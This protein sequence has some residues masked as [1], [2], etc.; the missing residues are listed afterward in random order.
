[1]H[2][3]EVA[4]NDDC[5]FD[6]T[7]C[8][9]DPCGNGTL[10]AGEDCDGDELNS[11]ACADFD[12]YIGGTLA[13]NDDCTFDMALCEED[14][15]GNGTIDTGEDC[16][17]TNLNSMGCA[18]VDG[19]AEGTLACN[20]D[21]TFNTDE[22]LVDECPEDM[23]DTAYEN[24]DLASAVG[25][26]VAGTSELWLCNAG[27]VGEEDWFFVDLAA[28]DVLVAR[29]EFNSDWLDID[30]YLYDSAGNELESSET[31]NDVEEILYIAGDAAETVYL[32]AIPF[33][34]FDGYA[35]YTATVWINPACTIDD[36]C[37]LSHYCMDYDCVPG[38]NGDERCAEGE[39]CEDEVCITGCRLDEECTTDGEICLDNLCQPG[40]RLD[41]ECTTEG[42]VCL[43]ATNQCGPGCRLDEDCADGEVCFDNACLVPDCLENADCAMG[44]ACVDYACVMTACTEDADCAGYDLV[45]LVD[46]GYCV[47]CNTAADCID[48]ED[49]LCTANAC[50]LNCVEDAYEPNGTMDAAAALT[51]PV[52]DTGLTLCGGGDH[53]WFTVDV[54]GPATLDAEILFTDDLGDVDLYLYAPDSADFDEDYL[55]RGYSSSDNEEV[56]WD[57]PS[58]ASGTY[59]L[60]VEIFSEDEYGQA[61]DLNLT[62]TA[63]GCLVNE[64]CVA[65]ES[66]DTDTNTCVGTSCTENADCADYD[67]VCNTTAGYC[68]ECVVDGDCADFYTCV[69]A[70]CVFTC[71]DDQFE[72]NDNMEQALDIIAASYE[73]F[74]CDEMGGQ[75]DWFTFDLSAGDVFAANAAF[76]DSVVDINLYLYDAEETWLDSSTSSVN[77]YE[78]VIYEAEE[79][80]TVYVRVMSNSDTESTGPYSFTAAINPVCTVDAD[81]GDGEI[82]LDFACVEG[83]REDAHCGAGEVCFELGCIIPECLENNECALGQACVDYACMA[84][85]C[86]EDA[87]CDD[88]DLLCD[89][90]NGYCVECLAQG[91][92]PNTEDFSC[93]GGFC[94]LNCLEDAFEGN[95]LQSLAA[96]LTIPVDEAGL[97]LCGEYEVDWYYAAYEGYTL[98]QIDVLFTDDDGDIDI[99]VYM[100]DGT[101]VAEATSYDDNETLQIVGPEAGT[102]YLKVEADTYGD[103]IQTYDLQVTSLGAVDCLTNDDCSAGNYCADDL[104]CQPIPA[105]DTCDV[106]KIVDVSPYYDLDV[107]W[108]AFSSTI[109]VEDSADE[110]NGW[111]NT[112]RDVIYA[113]ELGTGDVVFAS[114]DAD[115]DHSIYATNAC[116]NPVPA[117]ACFGGEDN[118]NPEEVTFT[119]P[120]DGTYYIIVDRYTSSDPSSGGVYDLTIVKNP[121]CMDDFD[122]TTEGEICIDFACIDGCRLDAE[123]TTEGEICKDNICQAGCRADEDCEE[124]MVCDDNFECVVA[125]CETH[126]DCGLG[127]ACDNLQ[128]VLTSCTEDADCTQYDMVCDEAL[129]ACLECVADEDC[130]GNDYACVDNFCALD[131]IDDAFE[132]NDDMASA[133]PG[134]AG[135]FLLG[136]CEA[137]GETEEDW[138]SLDLLAGETLGVYMVFSHEDADL[139]LKLFDG[140]ENQLDSSTSSSDDEQVSYT[141]TEAMTVYAQVYSSGTNSAPYELIVAINP[142]CLEDG[143]CAEGN[144][145]EQLD[146]V[147]GCRTDANCPVGE[148]CFGEACIVPDCLVNAD[149]AAGEACVDYACVATTC[150]EDAECDDYDLLCDTTA[151]YCVEC[152]DVSD[153]LSATAFACDAGLCV[154]QCADDAYEPNGEERTASALTLPVAE[155]DLTLCDLYAEDWF[156]LEL[157]ALTVYQFDVAYTYDDGNVQVYLYAADN[158]STSVASGTSYS[159]DESFEFIAPAA[160]T[161]YLLVENTSSGSYVQSY[162]LAISATGTVECM[163]NT[164]CTEGDICVE[165]LC[166]TPADGDTC[167]NAILVDA[168]PFEDLGR[169]VSAYTNQVQTD[170]CS[171]HATGGVDV[172][173][174]AYAAEGEAY[175][176]VVDTSLDVIVFVVNDCGDNVAG[177][178]VA[179]SDTPEELYLAPGEGE[180]GTYYVVVEPYSSSINTGTF[181]LTISQIECVTDDQCSEGEVCTADNVCEAPPAGDSCADPVVVAALPFTDADVDISGF[182]NQMQMEDSGCTGY[183]TSGKDVVYSFT[184]AEGDVIEVSVTTS[185][186]GALYVVPEL[187]CSGDTLAIAAAMCVDGS[188]SAYSGGTESLTLTVGAGQAGTYFAVVD[189]YSSGPSTGTF[190]IT[191]DYA[192]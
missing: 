19:F 30:G 24:D 26:M 133:T 28:G 9:P 11:M 63:L 61:Y 125:G 106:P 141:A 165:N 76:D 132:E 112:G 158:M 98:Y 157:D 135:S 44:E 7:A 127:Q 94:E 2:A 95:D 114:A 33:E 83:C 6:L 40:C 118:G 160:G 65:G 104:S 108:Y 124:P 171:Y 71:T 105:G 150:T 74:L 82:C 35:P 88:Y 12:G 140:D 191:A 126:A 56:S 23:Y 34:N 183:G 77:D 93:E 43:D 84:T 73:L 159:D 81:C 152:L 5:T 16:D 67:Q 168:L 99:G 68:V 51:P 128:C 162:D 156:T 161:Y 49:W 70:A 179:Y 147:P 155:T 48:E 57:I 111:A 182:S 39:I 110:C 173:Y 107:D 116:V 103:Y 164:D 96:E 181:D 97:T 167:G 149:C 92:C 75:E 102:V 190:T 47:E 27:A 42:E 62:V 79:D 189:Y 166:A 72:P 91:D 187:A 180:A 178:C 3:K 151:G 146:C 14:P 58:A 1:M 50:A 69:D 144:I 38:C 53:D 145:C 134:G 192:P 22:C 78:E 32:A 122:C 154:L 113:I 136:L 37:A 143:D 87:E 8:D 130:T 139:E 20:D 148:V 85:T 188:D 174:E 101:L 129:G 10:D 185:Y 21:C 123:C 138:F 25:P 80:I 45:C 131:C 163:A 186:D 142:A 17:G 15:C 176:V 121:A 52:A 117:G 86:T 36:D 60:K 137:T 115:F 13:C 18:D 66:C 175:H 177:A 4:C 90:T 119:A 64:D 170:D 46:S 172:V 109:E 184:A 89:T 59:Y 55:V 54:T 29:M 153:C 41:E 100:A 120:A 31:A 169:D